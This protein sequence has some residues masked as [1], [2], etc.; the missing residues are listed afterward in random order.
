MK[1]LEQWF[2]AAAVEAHKSLCLRSACGAVLISR[3]GAVLG[4]GYNAP[5]G[6]DLTRRVCGT[7]QPSVRKPKC[8]RTC[9]VHAEWRALSDALV[10]HPAEVKGSTMVFCRVQPSGVIQHSGRPYCTVCSRLT[11]DAGVGAWA[12]WHPEGMRVYSAEDYH[13]LSERYDE[14]PD[15]G[16]AGSGSPLRGGAAVGS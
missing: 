16:L 4:T 10:R 2:A 7:L 9:C 5:P 13:W 3:A 1:D 6:D 12:L 14:A 8:D 15:S 11:L